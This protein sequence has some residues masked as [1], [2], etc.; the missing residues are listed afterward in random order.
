MVMIV[1]AQA[2]MKMRIGQIV[3]V[4]NLDLTQE[5]F[6][7]IGAPHAAVPSMAI[8][9]ITTLPLNVWSPMV[10]G[11]KSIMPRSLISSDK[12]K[13]EKKMGEVRAMMF[14][15]RMQRMCQKLYAVRHSR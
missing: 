9:A 3:L 4:E 15:H 5:G 14:A 8:G 1:K 6:I 12:R 13:R 2:V 10:R 11:D 7:I